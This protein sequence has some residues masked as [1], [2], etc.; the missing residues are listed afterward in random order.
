M[1]DPRAQQ[2]LDVRALLAQALGAA[3]AAVESARRRHLAAV[4]RRDRIAAA[5]EK[6]KVKLALAR[7][8]RLRDIDHRAHDDLA[9][10][11]GAAA[12]AG[13]A[14][15][16]GAAGDPWD[17]WQPTPGAPGDSAPEPLRRGADA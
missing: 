7:D 3:D 5:A 15:A 12:A 16:P 11:A 4:E 14:G 1:P 2:V 9:A 13:Q 8:S 10:L 6:Q 17:R